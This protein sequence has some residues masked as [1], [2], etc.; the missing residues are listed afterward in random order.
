LSAQGATRPSRLRSMGRALRHRNYRLFFAGQSISL[1]GTW[2]TQVASSWLIYRLTNSALLLGLAGFASQAPLFVLGPFAGVIVDRLDRRR[3][4]LIT[5]ACAMLQSSLLAYFALRGTIGVTH[6][7]ALNLFQGLVNALD[8]PARQSML[9][10]L[11]EDRAD[12]PN[13]VALNSSMVNVARLL[14]P[15][16]AGVLIAAVGEGACFLIDAVSYVAVIASLLAMRVGSRPLLVSARV[17]TQL[18]EGV[19]Y[20]LGFPPIRALLTLLGLASLMGMPYATLMPM[21]VRKL[22][23]GDATLLGF[24]TASSGLGALAAALYLASRSTVVGLGRVIALGAA[25]FGAS[26]LGLALSRSALL[27]ALLLVL[28]G[29]SMMI[30]MAS[31][32][33]ILQTIVDEQQRGRVM[34]LYGVAVFGMAPF[35]SLLAGTLADRIGPSATLALGGAVCLLNAARFARQLPLLRTHIRPIYQRLGIVPELARGVASASVPEVP[36]PP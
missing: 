24:M 7:L 16:V 36:S 13:A 29:F 14:G 35:G 10:D 32:N 2:L 9:V 11:L 5:Q 31:S 6:I 33:T 4:L 19:R 8:M 22:F 26:L 23:H 1:I 28:T 34:S 21:I 20:A 3:V 17:L 30:Q 27:S 15:S 12:L 18:R 25:L